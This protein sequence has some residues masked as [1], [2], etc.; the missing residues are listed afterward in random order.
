MRF[1]LA[2][3]TL[4][5]LWLL[6]RVDLERVERQRFAEELSD[7][8]SYNYFSEGL[9]DKT[10]VL[11]THQKEGVPCA[12]WL[13]TMIWRADFQ[14]V[15]DALRKAGFT[16]LGCGYQRQAIPKER[17]ATPSLKGVG[18]NGILISAVIDSVTPILKKEN[19]LD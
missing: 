1:F 13:A 14:D 12:A 2:A 15:R 10:L 8:G 18:F 3:V 6:H 11:G 7:G 16:E 17:Q 19:H 4:I 5:A 9:L